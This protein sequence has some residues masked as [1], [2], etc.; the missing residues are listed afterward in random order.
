MNPAVNSYLRGLDAHL[1]GV[2]DFDSRIRL[3]ED[4]RRRVDRLE[5]ALGQ[6]ALCDRNAPQPTRFSALDLALLHGA[7]TIRLEAARAERPA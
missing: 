7:L 2:R 3:L 1:A 5:R 4:E 6:W